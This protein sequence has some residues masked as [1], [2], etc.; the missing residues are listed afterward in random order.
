MT[1]E[2]QLL[3]DAVFTVLEGFTLP[4]EARKVLETVYY[5][6]LSAPAQPTNLLPLNGMT[7]EAAMQWLDGL[8]ATPPASQEQPLRPA[9]WMDAAHAAAKAYTNKGDAENKTT[10]FVAGAMWGAVTPP[11]SQEQAKWCEYVAGV[12]WHWLRDSGAIRWEEDRCIE[13]MA[14]I[15]ER[16][17]W[18]LKREGKASQEQAQPSTSGWIETVGSAPAKLDWEVDHPLPPPSEASRAMIHAMQAVE[19]DG[20]AAMYKAALAAARKER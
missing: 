2:T 3:R 18:A 10:C 11:A 5:S 6:A 17:L 19:E 9:E 14:G 12:V 13:A 8:R 1:T 16:L 7:K 20:Y 15:I 4:H